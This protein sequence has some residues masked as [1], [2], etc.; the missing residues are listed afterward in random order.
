MIY[1]KILVLLEK[2]VMY[3]KDPANL[4]A[5]ALKSR[6]GNESVEANIIYPPINLN[7]NKKS[8]QGQITGTLGTLGS[9][10]QD[11]GSEFQKTSLS[12]RD[13]LVLGMEALI[14]SCNDHEKI[15]LS[16]QLHNKNFTFLK[17]IIFDS[18]DDEW[19][20]I[21]KQIIKKL[22]VLIL[23]IKDK[24]PNSEN[25]EK[26][27]DFFV[28]FINNFTQ[29][30]LKKFL[31]QNIN[32]VSQIK[33]ILFFSATTKEISKLLEKLKF[34][35]ESE[36]GELLDVLSE[37]LDDY[38]KAEIIR[39]SIKISK[40]LSEKYIKL[41]RSDKNDYDYLIQ[42]FSNII[43]S[44]NFVQNVEIPFVRI[45]F[46]LW[47]IAKQNKYRD[48]F[49]ELA[50]NFK[51]V[52]SI[53][54]YNSK[55]IIIKELQYELKSRGYL[56]ELMEFQ[57]ENL[58]LLINDINDYNSSFEAE[59][60][61]IILEILERC[62]N[63]K[64]NTFLKQNLAYFIQ[65]LPIN[66]KNFKLSSLN[67][68]LE[69]ISLRE[70]FLKYLKLLFSKNELVRLNAVNYF[71]THYTKLETRI[72][73]FVNLTNSDQIKKVDSIYI[74][75]SAETEFN[76]LIQN[77]ENNSM[78]QADLDSTQLLNIIFSTKMETNL[79]RSAI[80]QLIFLVK[81]RKSLFNNEVFDLL[82]SE[83]IKI[84]LKYSEYENIA[85]LDFNYCSKISNEVLLYMGS[86]LK[87]INLIMYFNMNE[88]FVVNFLTID[89]SNNNNKD[90]NDLYNNEAFT[91]VSACV[92]LIF[93]KHGLSIQ[94][95]I[96][97]NFVTFSEVNISSLIK[98]SLVKGSSER[99]YNQERTE[100]YEN[101]EHEFILPRI[102]E[103]FFFSTLPTVY[104]EFRNN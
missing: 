12:V 24:L 54:D 74:I 39:K 94:A 61:E 5:R 98:D 44:S 17:K 102:Y 96:F 20:V 6:E 72:L 1:E 14:L 66:P 64:Q 55:V 33:D 2:K 23:D 71:K 13:F 51:K 19:M 79:K 45:L 35:K 8:N 28:K 93:S 41:D 47:E 48:D 46:D 103:T 37:L 91:F 50:Q 9:L 84:F 87:L 49:E 38:E 59:I 57:P 56:Q 52:M 34:I 3:Y 97:L 69:S 65:I 26:V 62:F 40:N 36:D 60:T 43:I 58:L 10:G 30:S 32:V 27:I 95:I 16:L 7:T 67:I 42:N 68:K 18:Q 4:I 104:C 25:L 88:D 76:A 86:L 81:S 85:T 82:K 75:Q 15:P 29:D 53:T 70:K 77:I 99:L 31:A 89:D 63:S 100:Q 90:N 78:R 92:P 83:F 101:S 11:T 80:E 21:F 22:H 73:E